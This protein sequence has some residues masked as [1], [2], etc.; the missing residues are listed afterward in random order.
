MS[1]NTKLKFEHLN[2][3]VESKKFL[4]FSY[5]RLHQQPLRAKPIED[6][7]SLYSPNEVRC[8]FDVKMTF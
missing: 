1:R 8:I 7:R 5:I 3:A 4:S 2:N 6:W